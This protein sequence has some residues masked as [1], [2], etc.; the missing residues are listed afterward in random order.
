MT[1]IYEGV[2]PVLKLKV[3]NLI[4]ELK[5]QYDYTAT[6][7]SGKRTFEEQAFLWRAGRSSRVVEQ[8]IISLSSRGY[9]NIA[10]AFQ[11][12]KPNPEKK[13]LTNALPG[14][15]YHNYGLAVDLFIRDPKTND[16]IW[17]G[18]HDAYKKMAEIA[19]LLGLESGLRFRDPVHVQYPKEFRLEN[20]KLSEIDQLMTEYI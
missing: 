18:E 2:H 14:Q 8:E 16:P 4:N 9:K 7:F 5:K 11:S 1:K 10:S 12:T 20:M 6:P 13:K 3:E 17:D 19:E 15:S